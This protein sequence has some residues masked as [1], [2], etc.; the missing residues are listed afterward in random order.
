ME[1]IR[2]NNISDSE[3]K[4]MEKIWKS[5]RMVS[6]SEVAAELAE[7]G[8]VWTYKTVATF[9]L[10]LEEKG[11]VSS[12]KSKNRR[13]YFPLISKEE[14]NRREAENFIKRRFGGSLRNFLSSFSSSNDMD[15]KELDELKEWLEKKDD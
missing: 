2:S 14:Y 10:R 11:Y 15:I 7:D 3:M 1:K 9:M 13:I 5:K 4:V 6:V 12:T 8:E